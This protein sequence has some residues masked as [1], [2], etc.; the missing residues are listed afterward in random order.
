[1]KVIM[2]WLF[3]G[4]MVTVAW[5]NFDHDQSNIKNDLKVKKIK[6][7]QMKVFLEKQ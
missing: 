7:P 3:K 6:L 2:S 1:M 4:P 5:L